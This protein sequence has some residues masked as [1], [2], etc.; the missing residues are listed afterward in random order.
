MDENKN[1]KL[2]STLSGH[3]QDVKALAFVEIDNKK[4]LVSSSRDS[5]T[6]LWQNLNTSQA[7]SSIIFNSPSKP[8]IN[9]VAIINDGKEPLVASG[10]QDAM[11]YLNDLLQHDIDPDGK[12]QLIGHEG[13]ICS[14]SYEKNELISGSWDATAIVWDLK[15]FVPKFILKGHESSVLDCKVL[16]E[17][18]YLTCSADKTIILWKGNKQ[19]KQFKSHQDVI[20]KLFVLSSQQFL[21]SSN[22]GTIKLWDLKSGEVLNTFYGHESFVYDISTLSDDLLVS[23]GEDRAITIWDLK[24]GNIKQKITL[25][26]ISVWCVARLNDGDFAVGGSDNKIRVF[27]NSLSRVASDE[28]LAEFRKSIESSSIAEQS[29]ENLKKTD[30][31]GYEA[32]NKPGKQEGSTIMVKSPAGQIEA[33]QWSGGEWIKVGDVVG[34]SASNKKQSYQGKEYD[35]VFDVD[36]KDGEPPLKLPY[37]ITDNPYVVAENFLADNELPS[38]YT[39]DV[40]QFLEKNTAGVSIEE[41]QPLTDNRVLDPYSDAYVRQSN[42][43]VIPAKSYIFFKDFKLE[44]IMN[45]LKKLNQSQ[46]SSVQLSDQSISTI[47]NY[48]ST[49]N[50]KQAFD[51]IT[52][53]AKQIIQ[54]WNVSSKLIGYDLLR[55]CIPKV[56]TADLLRSTDAA[57]I[58]LDSIHTG[59]IGSS[60]YSILMMI[61]K[62]LINLIDNTL[63]VQLFIDPTDDGKH[64][65]YNSIFKDLLTKL[66]ALIKDSNSN[67]KLYTTTMNTIATFIYDLSVYQ[68]TTKGLKENSQVSAKPVLEFLDNV[69]EQIIK[70][71]SEAAYRSI[72]GYGNFKYSKAIIEGSKYPSWIIEAGSMYSGESESRF[73]ELASDL[74]NLSNFK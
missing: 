64:Y 53:Y 24:T 27:T 22:D 5:T 1:Y 26:C 37:N 60:N 28:E 6:R 73:Y 51:I 3:E 15:N 72:V 23:T 40:V 30:V 52:G 2:S 41:S 34:S 68:L 25:P 32:L 13:N 12:Y 70:S 4:F 61:I 14:L 29:V 45:G 20:R 36:I 54:D 67:A 65:L 47:E 63:F 35:Y 19:V 31:P 38:S 50:S 56:T 16:G 49:L 10:G 66:T 57:K 42:L 74:Q 7:D 48:L 55:I 11:I 59:L 71:S 44:Q 62:S 21:S 33:Y 8:F 58:I 39:Q 69:G 18:Q 46:E 17:D 43:K 9:S